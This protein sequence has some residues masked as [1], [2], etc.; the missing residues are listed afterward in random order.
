MEK[1][2]RR[3]GEVVVGGPPISTT[4]R[5]SSVGVVSGCRQ[6]SGGSA[7][8]DPFPCFRFNGNVPTSAEGFPHFFTP[9]S[10][11]DRETDVS[12]TP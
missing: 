11:E 5:L 9:E 8:K 7:P 3:E 1:T 2:E 6:D 12:S 4:V 10:V